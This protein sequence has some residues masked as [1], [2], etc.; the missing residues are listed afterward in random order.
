MSQPIAAPSA[1]PQP[2]PAVARE[3]LHSLVRSLPRPAGGDPDHA[4]LGRIEVA[5]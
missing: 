4:M 3:R 5:A 1:S 2:R